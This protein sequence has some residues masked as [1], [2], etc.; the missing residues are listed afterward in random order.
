MARKAGHIGR[1]VNVHDQNPAAFATLRAKE[2]VLG[3]DG[4]EDLLILAATVPSLTAV[5]NGSIGI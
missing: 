4:F 5:L 2:G 3:F 1:A